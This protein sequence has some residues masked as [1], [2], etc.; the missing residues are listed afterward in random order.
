MTNTEHTAWCKNLFA[1]LLNGGSWGVPRSGL[2]FTKRG[3]ALV[4]TSCM[5][6][7]P[8]MPMTPAELED[9]QRVDY[10]VIKREFAKADIDV[11]DE[12]S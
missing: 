5:P 7:D 12:T 11:L 3:D 2:I 1:M 9:Y 6:H 10:N 8:N 4:L